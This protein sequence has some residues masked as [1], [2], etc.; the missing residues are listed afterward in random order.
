MRR[1]YMTVGDLVIPRQASAR[2]DSPFYVAD[3]VE[4]WGRKVDIFVDGVKQNEVVSFD[5]D[6]GWVR[7]NKIGEDGKPFIEG[8]ELATEIKHGEVE[9]KMTE[10]AKNG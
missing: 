1:S 3:V 8:D 5:V 6:A 10:D 7:T 2:K 9:I 4:T